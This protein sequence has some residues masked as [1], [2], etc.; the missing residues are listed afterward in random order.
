MIL[1]L[2]SDNL[3]T[4][5]LKLC[6]NLIYIILTQNQSINARSKERLVSSHQHGVVFVNKMD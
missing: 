6:L 4:F 3:L 1:I 5:F 2:H